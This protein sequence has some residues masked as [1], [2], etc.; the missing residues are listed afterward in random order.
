MS[1]INDALKKAQKAQSEGMAPLPPMG[2]SQALSHTMGKGQL[3]KIFFAAVIVLGIF[4]SAVAFLVVAVR[5][6]RPNGQ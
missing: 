2:Q 1:L 5:K 3:M 6:P 4:G